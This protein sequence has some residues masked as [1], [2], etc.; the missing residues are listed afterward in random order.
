MSE[1]HGPR[2]RRILQADAELSPD[3][4]DH[5]QTRAWLY[6]RF[7]RYAASSAARKTSDPHERERWER[8]HD[9]AQALLRSE[10]WKTVDEARRIVLEYPDLLDRLYA[11]SGEEPHRERRLDPNDPAGYFLDLDAHGVHGKRCPIG[12]VFDPEATEFPDLGRGACVP[13][14]EYD[15][16]AHPELYDP[17]ALKRWASE[18]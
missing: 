16:C 10:R 2:L 5:L 11:A 7:V 13:R 15:P 14:D 8:E 18:S 17:A 6:A 9:R 3:E 4:L 1:R 12:T